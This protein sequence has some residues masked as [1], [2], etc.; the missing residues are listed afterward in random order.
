VISLGGRLGYEDDGN[1][2]NTQIVYH[3]Y[4]AAPL[5]FEVRGLPAKATSETMDKYRGA[6]V[7]VVID[8]EH[9]SLVIPSYSE[10]NA[11]DKE[12]KEVKKFAAGASHFGN[13]IKAVRSRKATDLHADI[14]EGHL[15]AALVHMGNISYRLGQQMPCEQM[16]EEIKGNPDA[17]ECLGRMQEHLAANSV[18]LAKTPA[19]FG[20]YLKMDPKT[21]RF[22]QN[23]KADELLTREYRKPFV[24]PE[25]V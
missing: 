19:T 3:E 8:C 23:S 7:G 4:K 14:Q 10:A 21:E 5:I 13:F 1:T 20:A 25:K 15:S 6:S 24:V 2:P 12:G 11:F 16:R 18:D 22:I 9:G 17:L